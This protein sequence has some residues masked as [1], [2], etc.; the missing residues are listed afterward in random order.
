M[1]ILKIDL[2]HRGWNHIVNNEGSLTTVSDEESLIPA[3][4]YSA[5]SNLQFSHILVPVNED[6]EYTS[7]ILRCILFCMSDSSIRTDIAGMFHDFIVLVDGEGFDNE[8]AKEFYDTVMP[9]LEEIY[10]FARHIAC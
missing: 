10:A 1:D 2:H 8:Y 5:K 6:P 9:L 3:L 7:D 4:T